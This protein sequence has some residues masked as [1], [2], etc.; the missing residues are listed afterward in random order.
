MRFI[1]REKF[2]DM[3][4]REKI[5]SVIESLL[6]INDKPIE[7]NELRE[8]VDVDRREIEESLEELISEHDRRPSAGICIVKVAGGYQ[9]C[10]KPDNELWVKKMYRGRNRYRLTTASLE[11]LAIIVYKQPIT[12]MEVEAI[13]GVNVDGVMKHL[14]DLG[15]IKIGGRKKVIGRPF[16]YTTTR[17]FLEYFGL[18]SLKDL[19]KLEEFVS[20][21][22]KD[23]LS[24]KKE[25]IES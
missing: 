21:A 7:V 3:L 17:K 15:L 10:S 19:P 2:N 12:R 23:R 9:M 8:V 11:T 24:F 16:L 14:L 18:N 1:D 20:L 4:E 25:N 5:K 6:F 22:E 13:R